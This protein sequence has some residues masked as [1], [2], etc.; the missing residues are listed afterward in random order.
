G[1]S[2]A[3]VA[4]DKAGIRF[5]QHVADRETTLA[6]LAQGFSVRSFVPA[7]EN[8]PEGMTAAQVL[9]QKASSEGDR[10]EER[11]AEIDR[12]VAEL[13]AYREDAGQNEAL[14]PLPPSP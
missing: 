13:P 4:A 6:Q 12:L 3:D 9:A 10:F 8:L 5:A 1:F 2:F 14:D 7:V 11:L